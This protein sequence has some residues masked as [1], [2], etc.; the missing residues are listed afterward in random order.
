MGV[1]KCIGIKLNAFLVAR[2][3]SKWLAISPLPQSQTIGWGTEK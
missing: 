1:E 2:Q 3:L